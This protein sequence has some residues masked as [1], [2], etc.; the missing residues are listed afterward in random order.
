M[1]TGNDF[2]G[3][4][5]RAGDGLKVDVTSGV[6]YV[7]RLRGAVAQLV[8]HHNGIVGVISSILFGSTMNLNL[9]HL[10]GGF[11]QLLIK[12]WGQVAVA[13]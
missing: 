11:F 4:Q 7:S 6:T 8:E 1:D 12:C 10:G 9:C 13:F 2:R 5:S 3:W